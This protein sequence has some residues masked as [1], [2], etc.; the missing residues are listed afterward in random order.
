MPIFLIVRDTSEHTHTQKKKTLVKTWY[1]IL[2]T[3][4]FT[5]I[6][7]WEGNAPVRVRS[8]THAVIKL[9]YTTEIT[10]ANMEKNNRSN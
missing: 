8:K 7:H 5:C 9:R 10:D 6:P 4:S 3:V 1:A 2:K